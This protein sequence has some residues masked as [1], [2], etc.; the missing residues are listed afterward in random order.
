M[1]GQR[2]AGIPCSFNVGILGG[3][4]ADGGHYALAGDVLAHLH[5]TG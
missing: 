4:V 5:G 1:G 2:V 3:G